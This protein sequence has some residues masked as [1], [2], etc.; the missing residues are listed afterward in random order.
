MLLRATFILMLEFVL[1]SCAGRRSVDKREAAVAP[2]RMVGDVSLVNEEMGFVLIDAIQSPRP[3]TQLQAFSGSQQET[4]LLKV[5]PERKPPF[6]IADILRGTPHAGDR[7]MLAENKA[8]ENKPAE[9][10]PAEI[11]PA[12]IKPS[13]KAPRSAGS[14]Q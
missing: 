1:C 11:K 13:K 14:Q 4:A 3:G 10:K 12:E 5:S 2:F 9:I 6:I 8:D 7:A